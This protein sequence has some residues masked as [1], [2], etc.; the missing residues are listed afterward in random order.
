MLARILVCDD[1]RTRNPWPSLRGDIS[2]ARLDPS[3]AQQFTD[4]F[5]DVIYNGYGSWRSA[6]APSQ[7]RPT[8]AGT[9]D[10]GTG[11]RLPGGHPR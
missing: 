9:G 5:G 10:V 11:C 3:L 7:R 1:V 6:L 4:A 2:G 8:C